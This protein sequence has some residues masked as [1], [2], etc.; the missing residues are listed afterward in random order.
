MCEKPLVSAF[1][2][3]QLIGP[4]K[5]TVGTLLKYKTAGSHSRLSE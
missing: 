4:D 5:Y 1:F 2:F 3:W